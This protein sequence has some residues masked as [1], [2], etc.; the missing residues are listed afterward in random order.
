MHYS[1]FFQFDKVLGLNTG[2]TENVPAETPSDV[3]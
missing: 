3:R 1:G 2:D